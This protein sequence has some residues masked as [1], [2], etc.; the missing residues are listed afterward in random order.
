MNIYDAMSY[1][2]SHIEIKFQLYKYK[3][4]ITI[5][6]DFLLLLEVWI[7]KREESYITYTNKIIRLYLIYLLVMDILFTIKKYTDG[8]LKQKL[9]KKFTTR[10][11]YHYY[12]MKTKEKIKML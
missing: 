11:Y 8:K 1:E 4:S 3:H 5:Q 7:K 9:T 2:Q 12:L 6:F 10:I